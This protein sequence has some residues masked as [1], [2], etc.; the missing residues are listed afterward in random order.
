M[1][2]GAVVSFS[3]Q[4]GDQYDESLP[5]HFCIA[6]YVAGLQLPFY[7]MDSSDCQLDSTH[8]VFYSLPNVYGLS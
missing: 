8:D 7:K 5:L 3:A 2:G 6:L 1:F 4:L